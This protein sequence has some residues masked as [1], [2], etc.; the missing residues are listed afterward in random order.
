[1]A[2]KRNHPADIKNKNLGTKGTNII[3]DKNQGNRGKQIAE[4]IAKGKKK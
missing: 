2:K 4:Q 3:L 1:M